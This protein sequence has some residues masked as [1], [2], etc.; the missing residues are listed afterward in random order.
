[1]RILI[2]DTAPERQH[3]LLGRLSRLGHHTELANNF[4]SG[5]ALVGSFAPN[6]I[7]IRSHAQPHAASELAHAA[8]KLNSPAP[9]IV[10]VGEE[11]PS[12]NID[13]WLPDDDDLERIV[14]NLECE[15]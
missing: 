2:I 5:R 14:V 8:K 7:V 4:D 10:A 11:I 6:L 15:N 12:R 1:M 9:C 3:P 13:L